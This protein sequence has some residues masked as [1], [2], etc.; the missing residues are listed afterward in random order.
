MLGV[1]VTLLAGLLPA[2]SA[3]R[4]TPME[5]LRPMAGDKSQRIGRGITIVGAVMIVLA[6]AGL[7]SGIFALVALGGLLF[8]LGLVLLAPV[9]VKPIARLLSGL[10][11]LALPA[12]ARASWRRATSRASRRA[13]PS[14][15][16][17]P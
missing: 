11:S 2:L 16:A 13:R 6:I 1:G 9:L 15:P 14:R 8:L 7:L 12:R 3:S 10:V 4:V 17:R 5:V